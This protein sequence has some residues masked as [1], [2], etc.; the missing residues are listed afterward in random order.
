LLRGFSR[1]CDAVAFAESETSKGEMSVKLEHWN[2]KSWEDD[3]WMSLRTKGSRMESRMHRIYGVQLSPVP[4]F[5]VG[6]YDL[7]DIE[8]KD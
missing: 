4:D 3:I 7:P 6:C 2:T 5:V 8:P 1:V